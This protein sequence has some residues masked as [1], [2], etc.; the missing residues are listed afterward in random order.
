M[1]RGLT[2]A[3]LVT[4][5]FA[6]DTDDSFAADHAAKFAEGFYRSTDT[7]TERGGSEPWGE[8]KTP[9]LEAGGGMSNTL[10]ILRKLDFHRFDRV[11]SPL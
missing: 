10:E 8:L 1:K 5:V 3:L 11:F 4:R 6:D 9:L 7:H 2:L